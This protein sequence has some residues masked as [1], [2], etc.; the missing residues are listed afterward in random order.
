MRELEINKMP[1]LPFNVTEALN[2][3]RINLS[4][5]GDQIK[6]VMMTSS[7]P[8]EGKS[9][10]AVQLWKMMA[11]V[12]NPV[13]LIDCDFRNSE[14]RRKYGIRSVDQEKLLGAAHYLAGKA[15][16]QDVVYKTNV[17]NGF[18]IPVAST[19]V[20][21]TI[22][23]E[24]PN[25]QKMLEYCS[26][27][28][29]FILIDTPPLGSVADALNIARHCDGSVLVVRSGDTPRKVVENSVQ[30]LR[31]AES[32]L[33]GIVL[34]RADVNNRSSAY[35]HRYYHSSYY[36]KG[37]RGGY[38]YGHGSAHDKSNSNGGK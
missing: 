7:V 20:N 16:I 24:S 35:Y 23:L 37:Y 4:F 31:R 36:Y 14:M 32:P 2:Q 12:G 27:L 13:L 18:M 15:E 21:P 3:L 19:I 9:F 30:L 17:P 5:C 28:F 26:G 8:D 34:N 10:L 11:E 33:L 29:P 25:F 6:T 38:G 1:E 22:L